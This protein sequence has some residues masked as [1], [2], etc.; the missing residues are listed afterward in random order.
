[1][2]SIFYFLYKERLYL[3]I[4]FLL[5]ASYFFYAIFYAD[6]YTLDSDEYIQTAINIKNHFE[7]YNHRWSENKI[8]E[9]YSL[10]PPLYGMFILAARTVIDS[11]Y[12]VIFVQNLI[13]IFIWIYIIILL[14][15]WKEK[16]KLQI[17]I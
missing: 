8:L 7:S 2:N 12:F 11:D 1:M 16:N 3:C 6:I 10:R 15:D 17:T 9:F 14:K 4:L 5:H 13:S